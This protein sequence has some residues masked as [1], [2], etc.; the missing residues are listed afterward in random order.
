MA[1][2]AIKD[3][4]D[5]IRSIIKKNKGGFIS[6]TDVDIAINRGVSDWMNAALY[7]YQR[8]G[9]FDYDHLLVKKKIFTVGSSTSI[10]SI[11][12]DDYVQGLTILIKDGTNSPKEGTIYDWDRFFE[13][14][15]SAILAPNTIY[16]AATVFVQEESSVNVPKIEFAPVPA[17]GTTYEYT[18]VY[19]RRPKKGVYAYTTS[20][21]NFT[22]NPTGS[23]DIDIDERYFSDITTRALMY[24]GISLKDADVASTE[25]MKDNNQK[26]DER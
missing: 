6:P 26:I 8:T 15:N 11:A 3:A 21:G 18:L 7:K 16:P 9:K 13:I 20:G 5:F 19:M 2:I 1:N 25:A 22:Y 4:H 24:L 23:V 17:A 14:K 10:Q 12:Q